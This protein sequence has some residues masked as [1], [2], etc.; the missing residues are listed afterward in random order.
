MTPLEEKRTKK[1]EQS[2]ALHVHCVVGSLGREAAGRAKDP[3]L[4]RTHSQITWMCTY[5]GVVS[6]DANTR[7]CYPCTPRH[8]LSTL[9]A[10]EAH[11]S[12]DHSPE[13]FIRTAQLRPMHQNF[14]KL[15]QA[16]LAKFE[17]QWCRRKIRS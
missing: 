12:S 16:I 2:T 1:A 13:Q 11:Q 8:W 6:A 15:S 9:A 5:V 3:W 17:K 10:C 7:S 14:L 4:Q